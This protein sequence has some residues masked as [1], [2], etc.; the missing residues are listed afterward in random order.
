VKN[1][2]KVQGSEAMAKPVI[3]GS[4]K[5]YVHTDIKKVEGEEG[6]YSYNEVQYSKDE[7]INLLSTQLS[8]TQLALCDL[9]EI[10]IGGGNND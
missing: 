3:V 2:G 6:L 8:D 10:V 4:T 5:V 9:Y 1:I 7:Y